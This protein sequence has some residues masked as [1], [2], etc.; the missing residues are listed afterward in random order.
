MLKTMRAASCKAPFQVQIRQVPR[1]EVRPGWVLVKVERCGICGT[2]VHL[3]RSQATDWRPFGHEVAG[4][5]EEVGSGVECVRGGWRTSAG[6]RVV[7]ESGTFCRYCATCRDG[8]VDLCNRGPNYWRNDTMGFADYIL[9][10]QEAVVPFESLSWDQAAI[11]EPMGVALDM[12]YT[13]DIRPGNDVLVVGLGPI[14]LMAVTLARNVG[15]GKVYGAHS[16]PGKRLQA[17]LAMGADEVFAVSET[18]IKDYTYRKRR[19]AGGGS[20]GAPVVDRAL[21]SAPPRVIP[22]ALGVL[23]YGGILSFIGIEYGEGE[24]IAFNANT[25]HFNK[26]QL[27]ASFASPALY[28]P[29]CLQMLQDGQLDVGPVVSHVLPLERLEDGLKLLRDNSADVIKVLI[30]P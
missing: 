13:A 8:R 28:F 18:A 7:L 14:G 24:E 22:E 10:P 19:K 20:S 3:A 16:R 15:A 1:P 27:R 23:N 5:V 2:D 17:G 9:A 11:V 12:V 6:D 30:S 29:T 26:A 4:I 21:V 25:F